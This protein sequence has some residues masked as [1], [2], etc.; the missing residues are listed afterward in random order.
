MIQEAR[1]A[2]VHFWPLTQLRN[3]RAAPYFLDAAQSD[4]VTYLHIESLIESQDG[5]YNGQNTRSK[6]REPV[7]AHHI[8]Q[9]LVREW[10]QTGIYMSPGVNPGVWMVREYEQEML[11]STYAPD[12]SVIPGNPRMGINGPMYRRASDAQIAEWFKEDMAAARLADRA[13]AEVL[14]TKAI[15]ITNDPARHAGIQN[16]EGGNGAIRAGESMAEVHAPSHYRQHEGLLV[17]Y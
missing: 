2:S 5:A 16:D 12:G 4:D 9:D 14:M 17:L 10:T 13:Y 6:F 15:A 8:A 3:Y 11:P 7:F 1:I